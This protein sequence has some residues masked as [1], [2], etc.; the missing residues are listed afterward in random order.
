VTYVLAAFTS[1]VYCFL[2]LCVPP[3]VLLAEFGLRTLGLEIG[4]LAP[5]PLPCAVLFSSFFYKSLLGIAL[6]VVDLDAA[7]LVY[8]VTPVDYSFRRDKLLELIVL[9]R[10]L[11]VR[12]GWVV[13]AAPG[14]NC[15]F[16]ENCFLI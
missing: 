12:G 6:K 14:M 8:L 16:F 13:V 3:A 7:Y 5:T 11:F 4:G 2:N 1:S 15:L 9:L 10:V